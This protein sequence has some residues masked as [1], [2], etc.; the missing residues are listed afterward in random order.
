MGQV[1]G[2]GCRCVTEQ[3]CPV[4]PLHLALHAAPMVG[5][6]GPSLAASVSAQLISSSVLLSACSGVGEAFQQLWCLELQQ[7]ACCESIT[8]TA[9]GMSL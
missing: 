4:L 2:C 7:A 6:S 3:R 5:Q 1:L 9:L 8:F